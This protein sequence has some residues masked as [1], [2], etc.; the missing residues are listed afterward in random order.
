MGAKCLE[1]DKGMTESDTWVNAHHCT[2]GTCAI[3]YVIWNKKQLDSDWYWLIVSTCPPL[4]MEGQFDVIIKDGY[5]G[6]GIVS[7]ESIGEL[8]TEI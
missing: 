2:D 1:I 7:A 5:H 8:F 3:S 4:D 6:N